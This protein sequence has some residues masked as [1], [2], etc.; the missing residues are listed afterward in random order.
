M[1]YVSSTSFAITNFN[2]CLKVNIDGHTRPQ[3]VPKYLLQVS[4]WEIHNS[5]I[6]DPVDC[7]LK[8]ARYAYNI[9]IISD[10]T[11]SSSFSPQQKKS[12]R[13]KSMCGCE[14]CISSKSIHSSLLPW[15]YCYLKKLKDISQNAQNRRS[16]EKSNRIYETYKNTVVP[17]GRHI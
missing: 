7:G 13:Y 8:E 12:A 5:L 6:S 11:L 9:I 15:S 4:V 1:D 10:S 3:I 14:C 17:H 2:N 16:G